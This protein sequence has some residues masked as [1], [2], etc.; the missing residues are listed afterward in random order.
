MRK[1]LNKTINEYEL[2][3]IRKAGF[4]IRR[5]AY[6][7]GYMMGYLSGIIKSIKEHV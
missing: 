6:M 7:A 4:I 3:G 2:T 5:M 1:I